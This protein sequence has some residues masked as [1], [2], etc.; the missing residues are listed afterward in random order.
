MSLQMSEKCR[1]FEMRIKWGENPD[2]NF[3]K[4]K[5]QAAGVSPAYFSVSRL[6]SQRPEPTLIF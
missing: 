1:T 2:S 6:V 5:A 3:L 4:N